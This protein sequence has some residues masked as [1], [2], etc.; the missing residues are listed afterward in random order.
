MPNAAQ[1]PDHVSTPSE[2]E[3]ALNAKISGLEA[4]LTELKGVV[5]TLQEQSKNS[6][7]PAASNA[8]SAAGDVSLTTDQQLYIEELLKR[9]SSECSSMCKMNYAGGRVGYS[10]GSESKARFC[11]SIGKEVRRLC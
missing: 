2:R 5:R 6:M 10:R 3:V 11:K 9:D 7:Q 4:G 8:R 1:S